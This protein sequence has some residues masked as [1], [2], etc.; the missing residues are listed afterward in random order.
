MSNAPV[1]QPTESELQFFK[2][3][4]NVPAYAAPDNKVVYNPFASL[5][6][7]EREALYQNESARIFMRLN[8]QARPSR[9]NFKLTQQQQQ[10][11]YPAAPIPQDP[12]QSLRETIAARMISGDPSAG[13]T[14]PEQKR[15][16]EE[17]KLRM[18][19]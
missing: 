8:D 5:S 3:N 14:T 17:L 6:A 7:E 16:A 19:K 2:R 4:P 11:Q 12:Q 10:M 18:L 13:A 1:R 15:F 9:E